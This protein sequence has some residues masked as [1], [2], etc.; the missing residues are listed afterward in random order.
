MASNN[1]IEPNKITLANKIKKALNQTLTKKNIF[2]RFRVV[3][4]WPLNLTAIHEK[5]N[6]SNLYKSNN[7]TTS[8]QGEDGNFTSNEKNEKDEKEDNNI[9]WEKQSNT[10]KLI[11]ISTTTPLAHDNLV[12]NVS[13]IHPNYYVDLPINS[14]T[15]N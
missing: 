14:T 7:T 9:Q 3:G 5:T 10:T 11:N 15:M 12:V 6:L 13:K 2:S 4:I 1:Y 8:T